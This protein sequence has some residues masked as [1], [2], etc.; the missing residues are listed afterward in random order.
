MSFAVEL[1]SHL[2]LVVGYREVHQRPGP[3]LKQRFALGWR[4]F[5][6]CMTASV[7]F[8]VKSVFTSAVATGCR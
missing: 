7:M 8:W 4:S 3:K 6:Y 5:L 2:N 1:G